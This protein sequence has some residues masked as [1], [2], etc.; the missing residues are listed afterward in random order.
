MFDEAFGGSG[1]ECRHSEARSSKFY[2]M[3]WVRSARWE[4]EVVNTGSIDVLMWHF[5]GLLL[6]LFLCSQK[7]SDLCLLMRYVMCSVV[8][9]CESRVH[10]AAA[11]IVFCPCM[12]FI[13]WGD[14]M[15]GMFHN[16]FSFYV[17]M[18]AMDV[19][20]L[21]RCRCCCC[22]LLWLLFCVWNVIAPTRCCY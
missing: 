11:V 18:V 3:V 21:C 4:Q 15:R 13:M 1:L 19:W 6:R 12:I 8:G 9:C 16:V 20:M 14:V 2:V 10:S 22:C 7:S 5:K 17:V